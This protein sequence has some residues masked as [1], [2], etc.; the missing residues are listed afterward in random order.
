MT[1]ADYKPLSRSPGRGDRTRACFGMGLVGGLLTEFGSTVDQL[2]EARKWAATRRRYSKL[3]SPELSR[4]SHWGWFLSPRRPPD[5][6]ILR[7]IRRAVSSRCHGKELV[8][9]G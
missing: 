8:N 4:W 6:G 7:G 9:S 2:E 1:S 3:Q 5:A